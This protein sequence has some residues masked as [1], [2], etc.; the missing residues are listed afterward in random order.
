MPTVNLEDGQLLSRYDVVGEHTD[1]ESRFVT[2]VGLHDAD[3]RPVDVDD[4]VSVI[5]MKPPLEHANDM[6]VH[7]AGNVPLEPDEIKQVQAWFEEN[8]DEYVRRGVAP[9]QQYIIDPPWRD[10]VNP[11]TGVRRYRRYSCAGFVLYGHREVGIELLEIDAN[12]LP[13][14]NWATVRSTYH[15]AD[16]HR[17]GLTR[18]GLDGEGPWPIVLPGYI[19]H[20]LRRTTEQIRNGEPYEA[21]PGDE[22]S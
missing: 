2:H 9:R 3:N 1:R 16:R 14:V 6:R 17:A 22:L 12:T 8:K 5:H 21:Q 15:V 20:S 19:L 4:E 7:V 13:E 10:E 18:F 11:N